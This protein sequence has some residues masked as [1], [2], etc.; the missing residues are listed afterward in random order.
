MA[1]DT[2]PATNGQTVV[3][4]DTEFLPEPTRAIYVGGTGDVAVTMH[5]GDSLIFVGVPA[6]SILPIKVSQVLSTNTTATN[7]LAIW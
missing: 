5:G 7:M 3:K 4:S 1:T 2:S 6:G